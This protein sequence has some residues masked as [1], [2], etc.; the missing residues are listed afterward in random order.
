MNQQKMSCLSS[1]KII[2]LGNYACNFA[3]A[4]VV[5]DKNGIA[6]TV[7]EQHGGVTGVIARNK[8]DKQYNK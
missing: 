8:N 3:Q 7:L 2:K 4:Y 5:V 6:P 1:N